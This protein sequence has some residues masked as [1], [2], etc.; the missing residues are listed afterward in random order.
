MSTLGFS[1]VPDAIIAHIPVYCH[2]C[3]DDLA[4]VEAIALNN[5]QV[6]D[7]PIP[8]PICTEHQTFAKI[9][10]CSIDGPA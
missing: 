9:Y 4:G 3:G 10:F 1:A 2:L 8:A 7:I 6:I 5:R